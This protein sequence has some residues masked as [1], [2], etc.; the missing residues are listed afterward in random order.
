MTE[1]T[2]SPNDRAVPDTA[3]RRGDGGP[4]GRVTS[5]GYGP[6]EPIVRLVGAIS[7]I[8]RFPALAGADLEVAEGEVVLLRGPNGA[9]KTTLLRLVAGLASL[10]GGTAEVLGHDLADRRQRRLLRR[11][12]GLLAHQSFLY[13]ELTVEENLQF[14][15]RANRLEP[16]SIEPVLDRLALNGRLRDVRVARLSAGQRRRASLAVLVSRRP[17]LWLLDEPHAGLDANGRDF[18]DGL[19]RHAI[20]FGATVM[21][22]S[23]DDDRATEIAT[24]TVTV[25]G[26]Q[27]TD[28]GRHHTE[29]AGPGQ[30]HGPDGPDGPHEPDASEVGDGTAPS[31]GADTVEVTASSD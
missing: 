31:E 17:R 23:H 22:A 9:G 24:R 27:V 15:A 25:T 29:P 28:E 26:G 2:G 18:V 6:D 7:L 10:N 8:D 19:I 5:R 13:D 16:S 20:V 30:P 21:M 11:Q 12:T 4:D 3:S 14:W 1:S